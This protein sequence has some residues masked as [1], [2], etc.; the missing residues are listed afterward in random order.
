MGIGQ[1]YMLAT[2]MQM[3][4]ATA[5]LAN[6]GE[7]FV[8]RLLKPIGNDDEKEADLPPIELD[9]AHWDIV[10]RAMRNVVHSARGTAKKISKGAKYEIAGKSGSVQLVGIAQGEKYNS[11]LLDKR[12]WDHALF[13]GF[14]PLDDPQIAIA[15][16]VENGEG[17]GST[18]AP[19]GRIVFDA[20]LLDEKNQ[21]RKRVVDKQ[22]NTTI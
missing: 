4:V 5:V 10:L 15:V 18:A 7:R 19:I 17:G 1:G 11:A 8:P 13:I 21:M 6:R 20:Y 12:Q 16:I 9:S 2:P 3:A 22:S 14:A